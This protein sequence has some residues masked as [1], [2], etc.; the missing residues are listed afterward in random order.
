[1]LDKITIPS[2]RELCGD[3]W[4][5]VSRGYKKGR[6]D[7]QQEPV[8]QH[9]LETEVQHPRVLVQSPQ[10]RGLSHRS[11]QGINAVKI[12]IFYNYFN[13]FLKF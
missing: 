4:T 3:C 11:C 5:S 1:M 13:I 12:R 7:G 6:L 2:R 8:R 9:A 10:Q